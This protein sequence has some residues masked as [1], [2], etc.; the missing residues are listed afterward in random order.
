MRTTHEDARWALEKIAARAIALLDE[1]DAPAEDLEPTGDDEPSF[2]WSHHE[3]MSGRYGGGPDEGEED[4]P[5]EDSDADEESDAPEDGGDEEPETEDSTLTRP[6]TFGG[7]AS[8]IDYSTDEPLRLR[9]QFDQRLAR[10]PPDGCE[11]E[12]WRRPMPTF[13][14]EPDRSPLNMQDEM[15]R[16]RMEIGR[17]RLLRHDVKRKREAKRRRFDARR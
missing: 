8:H 10:R 15:R 13:P 1:M 12:Y 6:T 5:A 14:H 11:I 16:I 3:A 7:M 2:G 9:E 4:D 17:L